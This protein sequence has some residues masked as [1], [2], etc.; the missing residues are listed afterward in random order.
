MGRETRINFDGQTRFKVGA[1]ESYTIGS[2]VS[3]PSPTGR[4][5]GVFPTD[6]FDSKRQAV[7]GE[8]FA[9]FSDA[10]G[11]TAD[12]DLHIKLD[13]GDVIAVGSV[14]SGVAVVTVNGVTVLSITATAVA[15]VLGFWA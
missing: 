9:T 11:P 3:A 14:G 1:G 15:G 4:S 6:N 8:I 7:G 5:S 10:A 12:P 13:P 2:V